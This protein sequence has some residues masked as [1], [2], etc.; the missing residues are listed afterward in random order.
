MR[1]YELPLEIDRDGKIELPEAIVRQIPAGRTA[2]VII[3]VPD[4]ADAGEQTAWNC[5]NTEQFLSG[6]SEADAVYDR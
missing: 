6:Y 1:A 5:L 3:L 4:P 2:R